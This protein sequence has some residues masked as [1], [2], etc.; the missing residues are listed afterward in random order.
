M[1][2]TVKHPEVQVQL[3]GTDGNAFA[4]I[5]AVRNALRAAGV[6]KDERDAFMA[7]AMSGDYDHV[8]QTVMRW[9]EVS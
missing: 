1:T 8:L 7:E 9:V 2:M 4:I 5:G 3:T 6:D